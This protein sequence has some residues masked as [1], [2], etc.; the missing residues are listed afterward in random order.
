VLAHQA[1]AGL[2]V[3]VGLD[4]HVLQEIAE[5]RFGGALVATIDVE[6]IGNGAVLS[7]R[8]IRLC[9]H[10]ASGI[11]VP[12][13][14]GIEL[15][16]RSQP[17]REPGER[18]L[19]R[20]E[21]TCERVVLAAGAC[22]VPFLGLPQ[23]A[24]AAM[25]RLRLAQ[26]VFRG[27]AGRRECFAFDAEV[28]LFDLQGPERLG[29]TLA[30]RGGA[31]DG[32]PQ[33]RGR[34][35][36]GKH[37]VAGRLDIAVQPFEVTQRGLVGL[38]LARE[39]RD[40]L[41]PLGLG[42]RG[43]EPPLLDLDPAGL[44]PGFE[45]ADLG[46]HLGGARFERGHLLAMQLDLLLAAL[47]LELA[48]MCALA[49]GGC[50]GVGFRNLDAHP[51]ERTLELR[52]TRSG[53]RLTFPHLAQPRARA[54]NRGGELAVPSGEE[55]LLP[56]AQLVAQA[57]IP[58]RFRRLALQRAA[59]FL[60]LEDDVVDAREVLLGRIE[61][62]LG[63]PAARLVLG[64]ARR[65]LDQLPAV[66]WARA[67]DQPDLSLLDDR[68]GLGPE[69]GVHQELVDILQPA[70]LAVDQVLALPR[71]IQAPDHFD[72]AIRDLGV[73]VAVRSAIYGRVPVA[74]DVLEP[75]C[76]VMRPV[77]GRCGHGRDIGQQQLHL[78]GAGGLARI[79]AAEDHVLHLV[80]AQA[81]RALLAQH[82]RDGV[83]DVALAAPVRTDD[84]GDPLVEGKLRPI[85]KGL[86]AGDLEALQAHVRGPRVL[87]SVSERPIA[88]RNVAR[89]ARCD[90]TVAARTRP[91]EP[92]ARTGT[93]L[94]VE[95][96][97]FARDSLS[98]GNGRRRRPRPC[99]PFRIP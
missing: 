77:A 90:P 89:A 99:S 17:R 50:A 30:R 75:V 32:V 82:P 56:A 47:R 25:C 39:H 31:L 3:L 86:E 88:F 18:V 73:T 37:L 5:Q 79:A 96:L 36:G 7:N 83:G 48:G 68:V 58:A 35:D 92:P 76:L 94:P 97:G 67:E 33:C 40:S 57:L 45:A 12:G 81:L 63:G 87:R 8:A 20:A 9:E 10:D 6:V 29:H 70:D 85:G 93:R 53:G 51:A 22:E 15:L 49:R 80:A 2:R 23:L 65:L 59:L 28:G 44:A 24:S 74:V 52:H 38:L 34:V 21:V 84:R 72:L 66:G 13:A 42:L 98:A 62:Q 11:P 60:H 1:Q 91:G 69:A 78:G 46:V 14:F 4:D 64:D 61:L 43:R 55:H 27:E 71:S 26:A 19:P 95:R 41:Y 16:E 54:V